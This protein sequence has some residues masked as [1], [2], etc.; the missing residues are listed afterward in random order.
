MGAQRCENFSSSVQLDNSPV[1]APNEQ[2]DRQID[3]PFISK[4]LCSRKTE[5][6]EYLHKYIWIKYETK[7]NYYKYDKSWNKNESV[8]TMYS[9]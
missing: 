5:L 6:H 2:I 4:T 8:K 1:S 3:R 9:D 7:I